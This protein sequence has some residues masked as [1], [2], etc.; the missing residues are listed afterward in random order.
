[1][2]TEQEVF[3]LKLKDSLAVAKPKVIAVLIEQDDHFG[4]KITRRADEVI[5]DSAGAADLLTPLAHSSS[6]LLSCTNSHLPSEI[7]L[8]QFQSAHAVD[9]STTRKM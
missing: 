8:L 3:R 7:V 2:Q 6:I 1:M 4:G 9:R 5:A